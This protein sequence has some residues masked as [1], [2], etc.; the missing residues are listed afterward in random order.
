MTEWSNDK[1]LLL[2]D[3]YKEH[4]VL[5]NPKD[6]DYYKKNLKEDAW[7]AIGGVMN[8]SGQACKQKMINILASY[9]RENM[10]IKKSVGTGKGTL[11]L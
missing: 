1:C 8:E 7:H 5:W 11:Y 3:A 4:H 6:K 2:I 10:K 9:R